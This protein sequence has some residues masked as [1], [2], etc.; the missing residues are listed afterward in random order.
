MATADSYTKLVTFQHQDK[1]HF[2]A[3]VALLVSASVDQQNVLAGVPPLYDLDTAVGSQLDQVGV[4]VGLPRTI[5]VDS[6][7]GTVSLGDTDYRLLM[8]AKILKN[9]WDGGFQTANDIL[10]QLFPGLI[11]YI[12]DNQDMSVDVRVTGGVLTPLQTALL[13]AGLLLPKPE[14]VRING[15]TP[16]GGGPLFGLDYQNTSIAGLDTGSFS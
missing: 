2:M 4:W 9:H 10:A 8:R 14:G 13:V 12:V 16:I 7:L 6:T 1:P 11:V 3:A 5:Y 15:L